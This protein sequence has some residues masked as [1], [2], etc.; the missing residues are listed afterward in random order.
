MRRVRIYQ[1]SESR[2]FVREHSEQLMIYEHVS[3]LRK[4]SDYI[5]TAARLRTRN[6][7]VAQIVFFIALESVRQT[8]RGSIQIEQP[9]IKGK[10]TELDKP[11]SPGKRKELNPYK[12][13]LAKDERWEYSSQVHKCINGEIV[14]K[15]SNQK[16]Q[17]VHQT[18]LLRNHT[19][20]S[21]N[22]VLS[23]GNSRIRK[24]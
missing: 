11:T 6:T 12:L 19:C 24:E 9:P 2:T 3:Q 23:P 4:G 7:P 17:Y 16:R 1:T 8:N 15:N 22:H 14:S 5:K 18:N 13:P 20:L 10:E 21:V